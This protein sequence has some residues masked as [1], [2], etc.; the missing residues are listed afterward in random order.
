MREFTIHIERLISHFLENK[1]Y[2]PLKQHELARALKLKG[3]QRSAFRHVLYEMERQG[4]VVRLKKNRW[5]LPDTARQ[6][7]GRLRANE[8][9]FGFVSPEDSARP[10]V[11]IPADRL[12]VALN[13]DRVVVELAGGR[14]LRAAKE[15]DAPCSSREA[16]SI[17]RVIE[18]GHPSLVGLLRRAAFYWYVIPDDPCVL[19]NIRVRAFRRGLDAGTEF[20]KVVIQLD[21]WKHPD[22]MLTGLVVE[23]L[24]AADRAGVDVLSVIRQHGIAT[25]FPPD[26]AAEAVRLPPLPA[27]ADFEGRRDLRSW[28]TFTIDP[29]DAKD[30]DDA[31]SLTRTA[32]GHW[33]LGVHIAD[34]AHF[35]P[36]GSAIDREAY[37]RGNSVYLVDRTITMLPPHLTTEVCSLRPGRDRLTHSAVLLLDSAGETLRS[38]TFPS[39]IRS[40]ARLDYDQVQSFFDGGPADPISPEV[41]SCLREMRE[42]ARSLRSRRMAAGAVDLHIPEVRCVLDAQGRPL[43][44]VKR[45]GSEAYHLIEEFMLAANG[46]VAGLMARHETPAIYRIHDEPSDEQ[47]AGMKQDLRALGIDE[48]PDS[49]ETLNAVARRADGQPMEYAVHLALLRNLKRAVYSA[50]HRPHFGLAASDYTHFTSPIR[51]YPDL[52]VHRILCAI[53]AARP[54]PYSHEDAARVAAHCSLTEQNADEAEEESLEV[55]RVEYFRRRFQNRD[56]GPYRGMVV[57]IVPKGLIIELAD[58]LQRGLLPFS[59]LRDDF[60]TVS[61]DRSTATGRR[62]RRKWTPGQLLDV[63]LAKVDPVRHRID[64]F[65]RDGNNE[66]AAPSD[67]GRV[68][69]GRKGRKGKRP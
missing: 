33:Q 5:A 35:V 38:E 31:V 49:R 30:F 36:A 39:V 56:F 13:G 61:A 3:D 27:N 18:R 48:T 9:G 20:H 58:S 63:Y 55:K 25:E 57:S 15:A 53:E 29:E 24:G 45:A 23:D 64:F 10:D 62:H 66:G 8:H 69:K 43:E 22:Q 40:A 26:T 42:L 34:V 37:L 21:E 41:Q 50:E 6:V 47:W 28:L 11:F 44:L 19:H 68:T 14:P 51:R 16:G 54:A 32:E 4:K 59:L 2:R 52:F 12:G 1:D 46:V 17:V 7:V 65:T 67:D 60:Y